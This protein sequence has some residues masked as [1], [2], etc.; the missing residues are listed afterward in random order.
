VDGSVRVAG[1]EAMSKKKT[2]TAAL[3]SI[4]RGLFPNQ[5]RNPRHPSGG[6][7]RSTRRSKKRIEERHKEI[8][9]ARLVIYKEDVMDSGTRQ[10]AHRNFTTIL[11]V[12]LRITF[13]LLLWTL[14][15][16][17][18]NLTPAQIQPKEHRAVKN[19][20]VDRA[21]VENLQRG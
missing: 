4:R 5:R 19:F 17:N 13:S 8:Q 9:Q 14:G 11:P 20:P 18:M 21:A 10:Q 2:S 6:R 15:A 1:G 7:K 12:I 3:A 16:A